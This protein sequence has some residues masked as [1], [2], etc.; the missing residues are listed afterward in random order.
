MTTPAKKQPAPRDV[1]L[2]CGPTADGEGVHILRAREDRLERGVVRPLR[3]GR[4]I[5]GEVVT[6]TPRADAPLLCD[7]TVDCKVPAP[8]GVATDEPASA[9]PTSGGAKP[10]QVASD[11][12][13]RN[14]GRVFGAK[15]R[16][17]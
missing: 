1:A 16:P 15:S 3:E 14:W 8:A 13:R 2:V 5:T 10:A 12:Y 6:L 17:N 7:V 4:P 11:R 9:E